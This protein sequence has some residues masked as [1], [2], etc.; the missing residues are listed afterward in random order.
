VKERPPL[1]Q[2]T[3]NRWVA[4][5]KWSIIRVTSLLL[6]HAAMVLHN[7]QHSVPREQ[8]EYIKKITRSGGLTF[9][10]WNAKTFHIL[11]VVNWTRV[12]RLQCGAHALSF[13]ST[14]TAK[15]VGN[16]R[17]EDQEANRTELKRNNSKIWLSKVRRS[18]VVQFINLLGHL[19]TERLTNNNAIFL[20]TGD[21]IQV[22]FMSDRSEK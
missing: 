14:L 6:L 3:C 4:T 5:K 18:Q 1:R 19:L 9:N 15:N 20:L 8:W 11:T 21:K 7:S 10:I 12:G 2:L 13:Y 16:I 22:Y 17:W